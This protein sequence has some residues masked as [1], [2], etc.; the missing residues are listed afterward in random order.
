MVRHFGLSALGP[1]T[2]EKAPANL[3]GLTS[4]VAYHLAGGSPSLVP[5]FGIATLLGNVQIIPHDREGI[6][7]LARQAGGC[8]ESG[9]GSGSNTT[10]AYIL[11]RGMLA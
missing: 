4:A 8:A 2:N 5:S 7:T 1:T 6:N 3:I 9:S 11:A 10:F